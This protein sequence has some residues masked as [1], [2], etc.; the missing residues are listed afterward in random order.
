MRDLNAQRNVAEITDPVSG[1]VHEIYFRPPTNS[2]RIKYQA[3]FIKRSGRKVKVRVDGFM[4]HIQHGIQ[5]ITGFKKGTFGFDGKVFAADPD[6]ADF[7]DDW[8]E[9]L[10]KH[11]PE[12]VAAVARCAFASARSKGDGDQ[13]MVEFETFEELG[14]KEEA[15][16]P[17][18]EK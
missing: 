4:V 6:D 16:D 8:R 11:C 2:E 10:E 17:L 12:I 13:E 9:I 7:R 18:P 3:A 1:D 14:G 15:G 5:L